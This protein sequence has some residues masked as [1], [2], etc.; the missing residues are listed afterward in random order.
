MTTDDPQSEAEIQ[1]MA[2]PR[3]V[4]YYEASSTYR[5][6]GDARER[7]D[8][9]THRAVMARARAT[10]I[11][12]GD[13]DPAKHG[14]KEHEPLSVDEHLEVL[15]AGE[16]VARTYRH[17]ADVDQALEAG[18][19]WEQVAAARGYDEAQARQDYRKWAEGQHRLWASDHS[20]GGKFGMNDAEY[21]EALA[22]ADV[23]AGVPGAAKAHAAPHRVL[24][25]HA[26][27]DGRGAHWLEPGEKCLASE[28]E[29][30]TEAG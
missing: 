21:A 22:R 28:A 20:G 12:R 17:P 4:T 7:H 14:T 1:Q 6:S 29:C 11:A 26:D 3:P 10:L 25:A 2:T 15:A 19:T 13:Y 9:L 18:A 30:E 23:A 27:Q 5:Y 16:V 24:C 8:Q